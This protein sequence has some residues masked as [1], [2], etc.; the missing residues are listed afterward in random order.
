MTK[1]PSVRSIAMVFSL[2]PFGCVSTTP[3]TDFYTL[4]S[5]AQAEGHHPATESSRRIA[6]GIGPVAL[7][8][9]LDRPQIVTRLNANRLEIAEFHRWGSPL[10]QDFSQVLAENLTV[11]LP[12]Q[13]IFMYP[14][15]ERVALTYQIVLNI[16]RFEG[17][18][19]EQVLLDLHWIVFDQSGQK[20]LLIKRVK[21]SKPIV[22]ADYEALVTAQ[23][24]AIATLSRQIAD[25]LRTLA[26]PK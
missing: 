14:W 17:K 3:Q 23:S 21:I 2:V 5:L 9:Y 16:H 25:E 8:Q 20:A 7:P 24:Q 13:Q 6:I 10:D 15:D 22:S 11:L 4:T 18:L 19:G 26:S 1:L 12:T